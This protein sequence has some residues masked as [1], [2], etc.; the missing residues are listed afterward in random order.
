MFRV[1]VYFLIPGAPVESLPRLTS[2]PLPTYGAADA[3]LDQLM[4]SG[5]FSGGDIETHIPGPG[6]VCCPHDQHEAD[7]VPA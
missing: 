3:L 7:A 2:N 6:W 1:Y 4:H 5:L